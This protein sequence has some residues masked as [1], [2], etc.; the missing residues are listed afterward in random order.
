MLGLPGA[1]GGAPAVPPTPTAPAA[2]NQPAAAAPAAA[3]PL[4]S[5]GSE[6]GASPPRARPVAQKTIMGMTSPFVAGLQTP[7]HAQKT[8]PEAPSGPQG[9]APGASVGP[10]SGAS[11]ERPPEPA[12]DAS[13]RT[14]MG[15][16]PPADV[17]RAIREANAG[18]NAAPAPTAMPPAAAGPAPAAVSV[19]TPAT[20]PAGGGAFNKTMMGVAAVPRMP[21]E[22]RE[23]AAAQAAPSTATTPMA[24][25]PA[26]PTPAVTPEHKVSPKSDR[27]MLGHPAVAPSD[28]PGTDGERASS[29]P[30]VRAEHSFSEPGSG[31]FP[32]AR[33]G[34]AHGSPLRSL[35]AALAGALVVLALGLATWHFLSGGAPDLTVS[36]VQGEDGEALR[37]AVPK[38]APDTRVR[39]LGSEQVLQNGEAKFPLAADALALGDN[40]I[41]IGVVN[42]AAVEST[43]VRLHVA[44][45]AHV[46][47][48]GL[49]RQ[50]ATLDVVIEALPGSKV[51]LDGKPLTLDAKGHGARS[52]PIAAQSSAKL[53]FAAKYK[54]EAPDGS[55]GQGA[56]ALNLPVSSLQIDRPGPS[57]TTDQASVEVA[58]AVESNAEVTVDG[59]AVKVHEGRFLS[60]V[61]LPKA[62]DYTIHVVARVAGKVPRA[63]E[64]SVSRVADLTLAAA[65]FTPDASLTYARI[66]QNPVIYR[67]QNV[68]FEGRIYNVEVKGGASHLQMLVRD[69][70]GSQ[71][72]PLWVELPQAT[73]AT[74]DSW[75]RVLGTVAGEQQ[76]RSE[77][78]QVHTVPSVK[79]QYVLKLAR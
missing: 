55:S 46:D 51:T 17:A 31:E 10:S 67:G 26:P 18:L 74:V 22:A 19:S 69:C 63:L 76:F 13:K 7:L 4:G 14:V 77:R 45:R 58:G 53:A 3:A 12:P 56:L 78:G 61:K 11:A 30:H 72:C 5:A 23:A 73:D 27:T 71:R 68:A 40:E 39:F 34:S 15:V 33:P 35:L 64:L 9:A 65:S 79:A 38:A 66:A 75:V 36:V 49:Q 2:P 24:Q 20:K 25:P 21:P 62:G 47:V 32:Q 57:V 70:P 52:Y 1:L 59:G 16:A 29:A 8:E 37:V 48:A 28:G 60:R 50:P 6:A 43:S 41:V 54:V 42:G 44:Y